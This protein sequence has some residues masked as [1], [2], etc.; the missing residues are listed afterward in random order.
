M[1]SASTDTWTTAN[2]TRPWDGLHRCLVFHGRRRDR[3]IP[4]GL[5]VDEWGIRMEGCHPVGS[6]VSRGGATNSP[7][8]V[9]ALDKYID[10]LQR[11]LR[12]KLRT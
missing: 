9:Y 7:A 12:R 6:S 5:P 3:G 1:A 2:G 8:A 4:N 10:W 11:S